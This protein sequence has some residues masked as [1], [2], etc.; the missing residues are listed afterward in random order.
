MNTHTMISDIHRNV[1]IS[2][3]VTDD[4]QHSVSTTSRPSMTECGMFIGH[5]LDSGQVG[6]LAY[7]VV[8][9]YFWIMSPLLQNC[10]PRGRMTS[11]GAGREALTDDARFTSTVC[12]NHSTLPEVLPSR[13]FVFCINKASHWLVKYTLVQ[14]KTRLSIKPRE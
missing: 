10:L 6:D 7:H 8:Q 11:S 2:Q 1:L 3:E 4:Q 13:V 14:I 12:C 9:S 5:L